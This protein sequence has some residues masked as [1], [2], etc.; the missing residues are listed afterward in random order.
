MN[1]NEE[2]TRVSVGVSKDFMTIKESDYKY[3]RTKVN[4]KKFMQ[5]EKKC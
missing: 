3:R 5:M 2:N 4:E 1:E